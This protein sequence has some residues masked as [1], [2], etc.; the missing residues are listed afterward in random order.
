MPHQMY[1]GLMLTC[2]SM[3]FWNRS[4]YIVITYESENH[5]TFPTRHSVLS[6]I[7]FSHFLVKA[8][9]KLTYVLWLSILKRS[10]INIF[11]WQKCFVTYESNPSSLQNQ[12]TLE[13][14]FR[15][16]IIFFKTHI[17]RTVECSINM[18]LKK[19]IFFSNFT[20]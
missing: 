13:C 20:F 15:K 4:V 18:R 12:P 7:S 9:C 5:T 11:L 2:T 17:N 10:N 8:N 14:K 3:T 1:I 16:N 19:I 6:T